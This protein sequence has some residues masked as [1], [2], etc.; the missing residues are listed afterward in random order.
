MGK[1]VP[2]SLRSRKLVFLR[3]CLLIGSRSLIPS[4]HSSQW[5][6]HSWVKQQENAAETGEGKGGIEVMMKEFYFY[7]LMKKEE[8]VSCLISA[9]LEGP[10]KVIRRGKFW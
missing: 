8:S 4:P 1:D 5:N 3:T 2:E 6:K 9:Q 10:L 7:S